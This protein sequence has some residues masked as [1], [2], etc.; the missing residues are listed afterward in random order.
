MYAA[1]FASPDCIRLL[2]DSG[3]NVGDAATLLDFHLRR[4]GYRPVW[5]A[6]GLA[7]IAA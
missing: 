3:A 5:A 4:N 2:L 6:D 1:G 7:A